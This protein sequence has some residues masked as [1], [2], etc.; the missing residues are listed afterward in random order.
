MAPAIEGAFT[1]VKGYHARHH[2]TVAFPFSYL[3]DDAERSILMPGANL[4]SYGTFRDIEKWGLRDRRSVRRDNINFESSNPYTT[5]MMVEAV[6]TIHTLREE[7]ADADQYM[8]NRVIIKPAHMKRGLGLYN[9]AIA[10]DLGDMLSLGDGEAP[11][12]IYNGEG[13]WIDVAGQYITASAVEDLIGRVESG[14]VTTLEGVD[15]VFGDFISHY[16]SYAYSYAYW[17]LSGLLGH[18]PSREEIESTIASSQGSREALMKMIMS[19]MKR[20]CDQS[21][22][23]GYGVHATSPDEVMADY[24]VVRGL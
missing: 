2:D 3:V 12:A 6:N 19:D 14:E 16:E 20:D 9:K 13:R 1:M 10:A 21:M 4:V 15:S 11:C 17:L 18:E 8:W 22:S 24:R 7:S 23:V 5:S